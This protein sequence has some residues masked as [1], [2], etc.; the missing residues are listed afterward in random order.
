MK[1]SWKRW[2][3]TITLGAHELNG[4]VKYTPSAVIAAPKQTSQAHGSLSN[5][6]TALLEAAKKKHKRMF[7]SLPL[8]E[9]DHLPASGCTPCQDF[10]AFPFKGCLM[11]H[12]PRHEAP[13][14]FVWNSILSF[15]SQ[16]LSFL[17]VPSLAHFSH[18]KTRMKT[19]RVTAKHH[20][21]HTQELLTS[22]QYQRAAC[23]TRLMPHQL[24]EHLKNRQK[25]VSRT[26]SMSTTHTM[27]FY[28]SFSEC[29]F[30]SDVPFQQLARALCEFNSTQRETQAVVP[31]P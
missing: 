22:F 25:L 1:E 12:R 7:D 29:Q 17:S 20:L 10:L 6:S 11:W 31:H 30:C 18:S 13:E 26:Q 14:E 28:C 27:C 16:Q 5:R 15:C 23:I 21:G 19:Q 9:Q 2:R 8:I 4:G 24:A 3:R